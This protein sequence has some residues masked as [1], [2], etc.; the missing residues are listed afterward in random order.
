MLVV[1]YQNNQMKKL[2][3]TKCVYT[4]PQ[5]ITRV[6]RSFIEFVYE[7]ERFRL[8]F[9]LNRIKNLKE[10]QKNFEIYPAEIERKLHNG[11]NPNENEEEVKES[12]YYSLTESLQ[13]ALQKKEGIVRESTFKDYEITVA[14]FIEQSKKLK[15]N[16]ADIK[17]ITRKDILKPVV[18]YELKKE[19]SCSFD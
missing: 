4:I 6:T 19:K 2:K 8:T 9:D 11:W 7:K 17:H 15:L 1:R 3:I 16:D 13:F 5:V 10:R 14:K 18:H 12:H